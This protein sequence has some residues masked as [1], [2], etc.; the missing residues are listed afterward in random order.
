MSRC[1]TLGDRS[2]ETWE[3]QLFGRSYNGEASLAYYGISDNPIHET[4]QNTGADPRSRRTRSCTCV[5]SVM[6]EME[7]SDR[8]PSKSGGDVALSNA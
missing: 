3:M 8:F 5:M 1:Q 4:E 2:R 7:K 6:C